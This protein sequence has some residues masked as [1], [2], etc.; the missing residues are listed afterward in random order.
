MTAAYA[1]AS[2]EVGA[3]YA[4]SGRVGAVGRDGPSEPVAGEI[5][6]LTVPAHRAT[7]PSPVSRTARRARLERR[8]RTPPNTS[9]SASRDRPPFSELGV[10]T[11]PGFVDAGVDTTGWTTG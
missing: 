2:V 1:D 10:V 8:A 9:S 4:Y 6:V 3:S 11:T 5:P 7:S